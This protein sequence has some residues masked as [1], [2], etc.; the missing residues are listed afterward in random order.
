MR[1]YIAGLIV[2]LATLQPAL[3]CQ[4]PP[5]FAGG[6][7][8]ALLTHNDYKVLPGWW[9]SASLD[10][11]DSL[12][13]WFR[14]TIEHVSK[15]RELA[16]YNISQR[17]TCYSY[18]LPDEQGGVW[19]MRMGSTTLQHLD[20]RGKEHTLPLNGTIEAANTW[21]SRLYLAMVSGSTSQLLTVAQNEQFQALSL[22][23]NTD[24][25]HIILDAQGN[26]YYLDRTTR[27][28]AMRAPSGQILLVR[29]IEGFPYF[30]RTMD[31]REVWF[32][33]STSD[34]PLNDPPP[35]ARWQEPRKEPP[36]IAYLARMRNGQLLE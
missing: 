9:D 29:R 12:W 10:T 18:L 6:Q 32:A 23:A 27:T 26:L 21:G 31:D 25:L 15:D 8:P 34:Y 14:N 28:I 24:P 30:G 7:P 22:P 3:A 5:I 36:V 1:N 33:V 13:L 4:P 11:D 2:T 16:M 19:A 17:S 20:A 35:M